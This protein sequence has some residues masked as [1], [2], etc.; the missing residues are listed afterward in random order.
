MQLLP[1]DAFP[2][3][4]RYASEVWRAAQRRAPP[5]LV[6]N[7]WLKSPRDKVARFR[8]WGMWRG[9]EAE[10]ASAASRTWRNASV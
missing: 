5:V 3:G 4:Y 6:H 10:V 9:D 7:N 2:N 8:A 1:C